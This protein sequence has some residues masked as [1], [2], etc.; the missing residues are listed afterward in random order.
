MKRR[1]KIILGVFT[2]ALA[3]AAAAATYFNLRDTEPPQVKAVNEFRVDCGTAVKVEELLI[4]VQDRSKFTVSLSGDGEVT[5]DGKSITFQKAGT[6]SVVVEAQDAHGQVTRVK[7][8]VTARDRTPPELEV[9]D[10]VVELGEEIDFQKA[11]TAIDASDGDVSGNIRVDESR[12]NRKRVGTYPVTYSVMDEA[13][14]SAEENAQVIIQPVQ[15]RGITLDQTELYLGGNQ[16]ADLHATVTPKN[17]KGKIEWTS[18]NPSVATVS[19]GMVAWAGQGT[20]VITAQADGESATCQ[21]ACGDVSATS[22]QLNRKAVTISPGESVT[23][24]ADPSPSNWNGIVEWT[25]SDQS[26]AV[27]QDGVITGIGE[28]SCVI[29]AS[30]GEATANCRITCR[31]SVAD[32]VSD[33]WNDFV[34]GGEEPDETEPEDGLDEQ[35]PELPEEENPEDQEE[36]DADDLSDDQEEQQEPQ[37]PQEPGED[38][39]MGQLYP[40]NE[41]ETAPVG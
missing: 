39:Q 2:L 41:E 40:S 34:D 35:T 33:M 30:A 19:D 3:G 17:W 32:H 1:T 26:V 7:V 24:A 16:H 15:A 27:V 12:V 37:E 29:T 22:V 14:N 21:V 28:G 11:A 18:D 10:I 25:T 36:P 6:Y 13:G 4:R 5:E 9:R 23:L 38:S 20:C 8:P 31:R